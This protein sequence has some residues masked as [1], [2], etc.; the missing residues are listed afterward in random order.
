MQE[1]N[2]QQ[3]YFSHHG[4]NESTTI[5]LIEK[6]NQQF[7][8]IGSMNQQS[9]WH[10]MVSCCT[11]VSRWK[12]FNSSF[13]RNLEL[14][15]MINVRWKSPWGLFTTIAK[16]PWHTAGCLHQMSD[17]R[18]NFYFPAFPAFPSASA[19]SISDEFPYYFIFH[20]SVFAK[21]STNCSI[22]QRLLFTPTADFRQLE[23]TGLQISCPLFRTWKY[24]CWV[25]NSI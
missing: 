5:H 2:Q 24:Y 23:E 9:T 10:N 3:N 14:Q 22:F 4:R 7:F 11:S 25:M 6:I 16:C 18:L 19:N 8:F 1:L 17:L 20:F 12:P 13:S 15:G 21:L